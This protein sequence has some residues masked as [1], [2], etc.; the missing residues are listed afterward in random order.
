MRRKNLALLGV[1]L[2]LFTACFHFTGVGAA[3][4]FIQKTFQ[5]D[6]LQLQWITSFF[7]VVMG[8]TMI[9]AG[10]LGDRFG[11]KQVLLLGSLLFGLASL[12]AGYSPSLEILMAFRVLQGIGASIIFI[13]SPALLSEVF[14]QS[15]QVRAISIYGAAMGLGL[16]L[17]PF[18]TGVLIEAFSWRWVFWINLPLILVALATSIF[19]LKGHASEKHR[20]RLDGWSLLLLT[21]GLGA[22]MYGIITGAQSE[23]KSLASW[24]YLGTGSGVLL[25]L[26]ILDMLRKHPLLDLH[27]F[28]KQLIVLTT[29]SCAAAGIADT[30]FLFFDSL[31]LG[32]LRALSPLQVGLLVAVI[33]AA[34]VP[35][36]F[37][38]KSL[39]KWFG[40]STLLLL[41]VGIFGLSVILHQ[42][43]ALHT[44]LLFLILP[45]G[46][47]GVTW[48]LANV[49]YV[50][51]VNQVIPARE[52]GAALGTL[53]TLW[54]L[55]GSLFLALSAAVFH[56]IELHSSFLP[57]FH[58]VVDFNT[59]FSVLLFVVAFGVWVQVKRKE[60]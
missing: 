19:G 24:G 35:V 47:L 42:L 43:I 4:P 29:L 7:S 31:Y 10:K 11:R 20:V 51:A 44:P 57:A 45:F 46:L 5:S 58:G 59:L 14:P 25:F 32:N 56:A 27:I 55:A 23:W 17:G 22:L 49:G 41:S 15:A 6:V 9:A 34:Q 16:M 48:G 30:A 2:L 33:P 50:T 36:S 37:F 54:N 12:G 39:L 38:F 26:L 60:A 1:A 53:A 28:K 13:V 18:V 21:C 40:I 3:L 8:M 52:T